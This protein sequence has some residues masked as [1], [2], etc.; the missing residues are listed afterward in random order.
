MELKSE[1][2]GD[3]QSGTDGGKS[4]SL[5]NAGTMGFRSS[6]ITEAESIVVW[7]S[8]CDFTM[9]SLSLS[10]DSMNSMPKSL[11]KGVWV[12][13]GVSW[14]GMVGAVGLN[15]IVMVVTVERLRL[16]RVS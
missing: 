14:I 12:E 16:R 7:L 9:I 15:G 3:A 4:R 11:V 2:I 8:G 6:V 1:R 10:T 5:K 13:I